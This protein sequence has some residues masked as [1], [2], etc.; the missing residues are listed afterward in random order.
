MFSIS[1]ECHRHE[2]SIR[3]PLTKILGVP[4]MFA[5]SPR[6]L[7]SSIDQEFSAAQAVQV[8]RAL[9]STYWHRRRSRVR[10][11]KLV[12]E[13]TEQYTGKESVPTS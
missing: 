6:G 13:S 11:G 1:L 2:G 9:K 8:L 3:T 4:D 7:R 10:N 12:V 5:L